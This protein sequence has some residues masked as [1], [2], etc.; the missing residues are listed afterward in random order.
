VLSANDQLSLGT[1]EL[2]AGAVTEAVTVNATG[3]RGS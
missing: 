2:R 3:S 1:I